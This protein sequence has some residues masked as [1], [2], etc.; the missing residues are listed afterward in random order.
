MWKVLWESKKSAAC[1]IFYS[2]SWT[3]GMRYIP[4]FDEW[5]IYPCPFLIYRPNRSL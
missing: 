3:V 1:L 4:G 2:H 5:E